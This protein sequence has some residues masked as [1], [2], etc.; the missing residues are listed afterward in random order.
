MSTCKYWPIIGLI[1]SRGCQ[2]LS[3]SRC[4]T[5]PGAT[6]CL[7]STEEPHKM[8]SKTISREL[9]TFPRPFFWEQCP[10]GHFT[11]RSRLLIGQSR[12]PRASFTGRWRTRDASGPGSTEAASFL[13]KE[14]HGHPVSISISW[15]MK[16]QRPSP[17]TMACLAGN[18]WR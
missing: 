18:Y 15:Q 12:P 10:A 13:E 8:M 11:S 7:V 14:S 6:T 9:S 2:Q 4:P 1:L 16:Y 3:R 5:C 17:E